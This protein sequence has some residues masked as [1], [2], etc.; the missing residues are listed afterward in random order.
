MTDEEAF[1]ISANGLL[2]QGC[3][4]IDSEGLCQFR[5]TGGKKCAVG[6]LITDEEYFDAMERYGVLMVVEIIGS[7][8]GM[9]V[10]MLR[11]LQ[12]IHD[13][14]EPET[15]EEELQGMAMEEG[16]NWTPQQAAVVQ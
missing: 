4:S 14:L 5:G 13:V 2:A 3:K 12:N 11:R 6:F 9:N 1:S 16:F 15:W 7:L 10:T 8:D